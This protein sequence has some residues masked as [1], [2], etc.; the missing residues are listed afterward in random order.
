[1]IQRIGLYDKKVGK[2]DSGQN[3]K[4]GENAKNKTS[5][6][7]KRKMR[8][9]QTA[10]KKRNYMKFNGR[11]RKPMTRRNCEF[12]GIQIRKAQTVKEGDRKKDDEK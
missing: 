9:Q 6:H 12:K 7:L 4:V 5:G 3:E 11:I 8:R 10:K 1:M 2:R